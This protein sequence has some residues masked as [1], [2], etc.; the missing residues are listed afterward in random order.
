[1]SSS[2]DAPDSRAKIEGESGPS[3]DS[4][5]DDPRDAAG[6]DR[7][8]GSAETRKRLLDSA[9]RLFAER[10]F[11]GTSMRAITQAAGTSV[12]AANYHF[13][14]KEKLLQE[15]IRRATEPVNARRVEIL[16]EAL[17]AAGGGPLALEVILDAYLRPVIEYRRA[18]KGD[19]GRQI[20]ARLFSDPPELIHSIKLEIFG[21]MTRRFLD[22]F[23]SAMPDRAPD[24]VEIGHQFLIAIMVYVSSGQL[25]SS[26]LAVMHP[27]GIDEDRLLTSMITFVAA[28]LRA[29]PTA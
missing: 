1:M 18:N 8:G 25:E 7:S 4:T 3:A 20:A 5:A 2:P 16:D 19:E 26:S 10:G 6:S 24:A 22:E 15:A 11:E 9:E 13:G 29:L 23:S 28:G 17:A 27:H 21:P 12:S 14:S